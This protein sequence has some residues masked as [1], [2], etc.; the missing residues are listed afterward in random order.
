MHAARNAAASAAEY[1]A[2]RAAAEDE[3]YHKIAMHETY[4]DAAQTMTWGIG[5]AYSRYRIRDLVYMSIRCVAAKKKYAFSLFGSTVSE[6]IRLR[7]LATLNELPAKG[8]VV[9]VEH[10]SHARDFDIKVATFADAKGI[11]AAIQEH[12]G[13]VCRPPEPKPSFAG[14]MYAT[15]SNKGIYTSTLCVLFFVDGTLRTQ[16]V[17]IDFCILDEFRSDTFPAFKHQALELYCD[18]TQQPTTHAGGAAAA[19]DGNEDHV[20]V[21]VQLPEHSHHNEHQS[22]AR[23]MCKLAWMQAAVASLKQNKAEAIR[24]R[25]D[26]FDRG[27]AKCARLSEK[28]VA[29]TATSAATAQSTPTEA[30]SNGSEDLAQKRIIQHIKYLSCAF[31]KLRLRNAAYRL[32]GVAMTIT[33]DNV[34]IAYKV[35]FRCETD[36]MQ[37][38]TLLDLAF[39]TLGPAHSARKLSFGWHWGGAVTFRCFLCHKSHRLFR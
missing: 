33:F 19:A 27:A 36:G 8:S 6:E 17:C 22:H 39:Y 10:K 2:A 32:A 20:S 14:P 24:Y 9:S 37:H 11:C 28:R 5:E 31:E 34:R 30:T 35:T 29:S 26:D 7:E 23:S 25:W 3:Y 21:V 16:N 13:I 15:T 1:K 4:A 12:L 38:V 18:A